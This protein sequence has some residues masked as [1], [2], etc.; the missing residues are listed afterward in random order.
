M[1]PRARRTGILVQEVAGETLL[2]DLDRHRAHCLGP[3]LAEVWRRCNGRRSLPQ[4]AGAVERATGQPMD[5]HALAVALRRLARA[6]L[7]EDAAVPA[8][9]GRRDLLKKAAAVAGLTRVSVSSPRASAAASC[10]T[11]A[12]CQAQNN[13]FCSLQPCCS[14]P[15][16]AGTQCNK[17]G[18]ATF[19]NCSPP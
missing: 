4:I 18:S 3:L 11:V 7:L 1:N 14:P 2:Y 13:K 6:K 16:P 10:V 8:A 5:E 19:C 15:A 17:K 9:P 12:A